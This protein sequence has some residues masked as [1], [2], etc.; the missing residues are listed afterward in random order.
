MGL[1]SDLI[2]LA[3]YQGFGQLN[4]WL[5]R[6]REHDALEKQAGM[7]ANMYQTNNLRA[8]NEQQLIDTFWGLGVIVV[9]AA[10]MVFDI[11]EFITICMI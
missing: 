9:A 7:L 3:A 11:H 5:E 4:N 6:K 1:I 2:Q 8:G 10:D